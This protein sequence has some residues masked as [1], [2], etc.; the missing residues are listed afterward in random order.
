MLKFF[1]RLWALLSLNN[2][3]ITVRKIEDLP[4]PNIK[5]LY[6]EQVIVPDTLNCVVDHG[7]STAKEHLDFGLKLEVDLKHKDSDIV[8]IIA[9][10][11]SKPI[12]VYVPL[13][14]IALADPDYKAHILTHEQYSKALDAAQANIEKQIEILDSMQTSIKKFLGNE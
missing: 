6:W 13:A 10:R 7:E 2:D 4:N 1:K 14:V 9:E 8:V 11:D 5:V 3:R 12:I